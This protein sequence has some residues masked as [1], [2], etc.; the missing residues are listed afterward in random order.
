MARRRKRQ[1]K[2]H[3]REH[4]GIM[5]D[6]KRKKDEATPVI[7]VNINVYNFGRKTKTSRRTLRRIADTF[8]AKFKKQFDK[9]D[10]M[11]EED[12]TAFSRYEFKKIE[13]K[14]K[15]G[16][17]WRISITHFETKKKK[18]AVTKGSYSAAVWF[19]GPKMK[20]RTLKRGGSFK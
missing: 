8:Q 9:I 20:F 17:K 3:T 6:A 18:G 11:S 14:E 4:L 2:Q 19:K 13:R 7:K 5:F 12:F 16:K 15:L 10:E 1:K